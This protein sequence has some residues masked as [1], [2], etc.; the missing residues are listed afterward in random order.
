MLA[1]RLVQ[2]VSRLGAIA[3]VCPSLP[4][5]HR[6]QSLLSQ[7][8]STCCTACVTGDNTNLV[9][10]GTDGTLTIVADPRLSM[11]LVSEMFKMGWDTMV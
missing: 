2:L 4:P 1:V 11:R 10:S 8:G 6:F 3:P 9:V 7:N 5:R